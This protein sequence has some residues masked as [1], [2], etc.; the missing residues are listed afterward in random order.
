M[1]FSIIGTGFILPAHVEAIRDIK[2][3]IIDVVNDAHEKDAWKKMVSTTSADYIVILAP[4]D[5]H[6]E[7]AKAAADA[8]KIVLCEKPLTIRL[9]DAKVLAEK[10][11]IFTVL[12][13]RYHT[14]VEKMKKEI[15]KSSGKKNDIEMDIS[16][17]RDEKYHRGWKGQKERSGGVLF[18][19]GVHY[20]DLLLHLFGEAKTAKIET[21]DEKTATGT[22]EGGNYACKWRVSV[23]ENKDN[24]RRIFK[25][26]GRQY[27]F[28][29]KDNLSYENLHR[30]VYRDLLQNKGVGPKEA[31]KSIELIEKLY[32]SYEK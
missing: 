11:N 17:Y 25:I 10:P 12:Q 4:N 23:A 27:N 31:L 21:L 1:K 32:K 7:M 20:F 22:I 9:E 5:L 30:F 15:S 3:E 19:L 8:G 26:N 24:Q 14:D 16:I 29:S 28:S 13:L 2:G 18:N 6:F